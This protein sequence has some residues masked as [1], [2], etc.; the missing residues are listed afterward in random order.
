MSQKKNS[1]NFFSRQMFTEFDNFWQEDGKDD[2]IMQ[3][4]LIFYLT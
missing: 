2:E 1:H 3:C 4:A